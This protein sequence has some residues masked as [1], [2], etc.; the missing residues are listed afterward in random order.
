MPTDQLFVNGNT[1]S[2]LLF[3]VFAL[4]FGCCV[5]SFLNVVIYR[6]P[7]GLSVG[8]PKRSFC[9]NCK[10]QIPMW[11]NIPILSWLL[12][13]GKCKNCSQKI[14]PRYLGV[15]LLTGLLFLGVFQLSSQAFII[16]T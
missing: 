12:L 10:Y 1:S 15:E 11:L 2:L 9:P 5:G 8:K 7:L 14:S 6:L 13:R 3:S 16:P 4:I